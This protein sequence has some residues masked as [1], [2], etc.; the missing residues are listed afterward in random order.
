MGQEAKEV[1]RV[2]VN[3]SI[4]NAAGGWFPVALS[5]PVPRELDWQET[6]QRCS[7]S[8]QK[9]QGRETGL[10]VPAIPHQPPWCCADAA[11][12]SS[13][14]SLGSR[15]TKTQRNHTTLLQTWVLRARWEHVIGIRR[16][17]QVELKSHTEGPSPP[18]GLCLFPP[19]TWEL[20]PTSSTDD[21]HQNA[22]WD[23]NFN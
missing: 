21:N 14:F 15:F 6:F 11:G 13:S 20:R 1:F 7:Y 4:I 9:Y 5:I 23:C 10:Y 16:G 17:I 3:V 18:Q 8:V 22:R 19:F 12:L 2:A